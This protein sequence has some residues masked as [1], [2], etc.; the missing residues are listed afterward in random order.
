MWRDLRQALRDLRKSP[1][2]AAIGVLSLGLGIGANVTVY[3][4]VRELILDDLSATRPD[5][6]ARVDA[7]VPYAVY[8]EL[9]DT[10][11]F[12][13]LAFDAGLGDLIWDRGTSGEVAW[14]MTTSANFFDVLGVRASAGRL[15]AAGDEGLPVAVVSYGF[16]QNRLDRD[17]HVPGRA[18]RLNGRMYTVLGVL[19]RDYRSVLGHGVSP[20]IYLISRPGARRC[21]LFGRLRDGSSR[22]ETRQ[23]LVAAGRP[24][25]GDTL[26]RQVATLRPMAGLAA[27]ASR[28]GDDRRFFLFFV[29]LFAT[30]VMLGVIGCFNVAGLLLARSISR[31]REL[32]IRKALGASRARL[33]RQ[34]LAD[35]LALV[36]P[37]ALAGLAVDAFLRDRLSDV[38]WPSAYNLPFQFHFQGDRGLFLYALAAAAAALVVSSLV[39]ALRGSRADLG[40]AMKQGEPAFSVR[41]WSL[42][43]SFLCV[44]VALSVVLLA[45]AALFSRAFFQVAFLSPGFDVS[46]TVIAVVHPEP[47]WKPS[48]GDRWAWCDAVV[49]R[50]EAVPGVRGVTSIG[51]LPLMGELG[52]EDVRRVDRPLSAMH[53]AD[54]VG[55]GER[56]SEVMGIPLLRGRDFELADRTR[57]PESVIVNQTLARQLFGDGDP[58]GAHLMA[59]RENARD[60]EIIGVAADAKM[61]TLGESP[62]AMLF[63]PFSET[64]LIVLVAGDP[65]QWIR[66][67]RDAAAGVPGASAI[68]VR[69]LSDAAAGAIFPMRAAA[70]FAGSLGALGLFLVLIGLYGSVSYATARRTREMAIRAAIGAPRSAIVGTAIRA[71]LGVLA[72]GVAAGVPLAAAA[73]RPL[74]DVLPDGVDPWNATMFAVTG[75]LILAIGAAAAWIPARRAANVEPSFA[76]RQE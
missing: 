44:Q 54:S 52:R 38:R 13:G 73:I 1:A 53:Q 6:L 2:L 63:T 36:V 37:A 76:L 40:L 55:A 27:N 67:L 47:G 46:H 28:V 22:L 4:V 45:L 23:A 14:Q 50:L 61:R 16:W 42:R 31:Q 56:F 10:G 74:A 26:A 39:P 3:S 5:R 15:Y 32:A 72:C 21:H 25:G 33:I 20:E 29:M 65:A 24:L 49:R 7:E 68:D 8:R 58:V 51:I 60:L 41:R 75:G 30:A 19:P 17:P 43:N 64:Q 9:Q 57:R 70:A 11:L 69:P 48:P 12:A 59:G 66:P 34:F 62:H 18:L 71:G 35:G